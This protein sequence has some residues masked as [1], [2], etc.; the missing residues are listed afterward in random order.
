M[1]NAVKRKT[2][3]ER[4]QLT[5][6]KKYG[7]LEKHKDYKLRANDYHRKQS[8]IKV[9]KGK[10]AERNP[11]EFYFAMEKA[12]TKD[13]VHIQNSA[14]ANKYSQEEL[15]I[16]K[17]QDS[18]YVGLKA[19]VEAKKLEKLRATHHLLGATPKNKHVVFVD[20]K[21]EAEEFTPEEFFDTPSEL[22]GRTFNRP[23]ASGGKRNSVGEVGADWEEEG[24]EEDAPLPGTDRE[25]EKRVARLKKAG[26]KEIG[27]REKRLKSM[28]RVGEKFALDKALM[29][30]GRKKKVE[31]KDEWGRVTGHYYKW[32]QVRTK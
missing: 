18:G 15:A 23:R 3:K 25:V 5:G 10:A 21:E 20:S 9:L 30:K 12:R 27:E 17:S 1:R 6:R 31:T 24:G 22:L 13:G 16:M 14:E 2:H 29:G 28:L 4:S 32:A 19:Q 7:L 11:D 8:A 26:Y